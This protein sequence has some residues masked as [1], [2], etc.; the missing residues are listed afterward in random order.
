M[1]PRPRDLSK[2][3][4]R[5]VL[6]QLIF[7]L[8][9]LSLNAAIVASFMALAY[10]EAETPELRW[11]RNNLAFF[12]TPAM[13]LMPA[14]LFCIPSRSV[15]SQEALPPQHH[16]EAGQ[17]LG[18]AEPAAAFVGLAITISLIYY[19]SWSSNCG[20]YRVISICNMSTEHLYVAVG[21]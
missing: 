9:L 6:L 16:E 17:G 15:R 11:W 14:A 8:G 13:M 4:F 19:Y 20:P 10:V 2:H 7:L 5:H 18:Y 12:V 1:N 3:V 21:A